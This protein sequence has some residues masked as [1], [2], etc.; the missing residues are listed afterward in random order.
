VRKI[1]ILQ[2]KASIGRWNDMKQLLR[3]DVLLLGSKNGFGFLHQ[4][5]SSVAAIPS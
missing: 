5:H 1:G 3:A 4:R 2:A